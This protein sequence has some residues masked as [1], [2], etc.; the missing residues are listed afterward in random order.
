VKFGGRTAAVFV[1]G[2]CV[3][4]RARGSNVSTRRRSTIAR[5]YTPK[6]TPFE[7]RAREMCCSPVSHGLR[8]RANAC[9]VCYM[10]RNSFGILVVPKT[11]RRTVCQRPSAWARAETVSFRRREEDARG[12][13]LANISTAFRRLRTRNVS[14]GRV[15]PE[16]GRFRDTVRSSDNGNGMCF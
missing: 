3:G 7:R 8:D 10:H 6:R 16:T 1:L 12:R 9:S 13:T 14:P 2:V 5:C 4:R 15:T 11:R